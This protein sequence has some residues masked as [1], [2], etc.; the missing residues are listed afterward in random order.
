MLL[1]FE[2][3]YTQIQRGDVN[4]YGPGSERSIPKLNFKLKPKPGCEEELLHEMKIKGATEPNLSLYLSCSPAS[5]GM[6]NVE[7]VWFILTIV[8]VV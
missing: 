5:I 6:V 4:A 7:V 1:N 2:D 3:L 8:N